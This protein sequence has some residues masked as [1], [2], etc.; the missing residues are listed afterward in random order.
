M[1]LGDSLY[2]PL[3]PAGT[4]TILQDLDVVSIR[5]NEDR[6]VLD[7]HTGDRD[8]DH[9]CEEVTGTGVL[10][11]SMTGVMAR[12]PAD[13][14]EMTLCGHSHTP[15]TLSLPDGR[16]VVNP[17]SVGLPAYIDDHP[18][19][20]ALVPKRGGTRSDADISGSAGVRAL[21]PDYRLS[22][23]HPF[24]A[25]ILDVLSAY[26]WLQCQGYPPSNVV[27]GGESYTTRA[28]KDPLLT[29]TQ[30]RFTASLY[31][32][33]APLDTPLLRPSEMD[34]SGLPPMW[35]H[36]GD[37]E[38]LLSDAERLAHRAVDAGLDVEFKV[39]PGLRGEP[40]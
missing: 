27:L 32:G 1:N 10:P 13:G 24:P 40:L 36:V 33:D 18:L 7:A 16:L 17:G 23:E 6:M 4:A 11:R 20:D 29:P 22:P 12:L 19:R 25:A 8:E 28:D 2:G 5:G 35:I 15:R 34:L 9:L 3:D 26:R 38:I 21:S 37:H 39:W 14:M 31:V 30:C